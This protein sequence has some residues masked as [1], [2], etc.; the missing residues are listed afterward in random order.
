MEI[1]LSLHLEGSD[2]RAPWWVVIDVYSGTPLVV[3]ASRPPAS[4]FI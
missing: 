1:S 4:T 3:K 2:K